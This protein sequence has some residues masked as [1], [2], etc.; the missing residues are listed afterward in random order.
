MYTVFGS[1]G[2]TCSRPICSV[3]A[4][5]SDIHVLPPSVLLKTPH[6]GEIELREFCSPVP[7]YTV[8]VSD[9]AMAMSPIDEQR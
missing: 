6:P 1:R 8:L 5:P 4:R 2:C 9:G 3:S 7:T